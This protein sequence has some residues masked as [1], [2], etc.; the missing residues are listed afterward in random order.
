MN[1]TA[2]MSS[3]SQVLTKKMFCTVKNGRMLNLND[4]ATIAGSEKKVSIKLF[5]SQQA[6]L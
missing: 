3:Y 1:V 6:H 5:F 4:M 2:A